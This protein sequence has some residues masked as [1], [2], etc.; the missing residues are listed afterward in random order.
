MIFYVILIGTS[1]MTK[2]VDL[3]S[4]SSSLISLLNC[5]CKYYVH[6]YQIFYSYF[7]TFFKSNSYQSVT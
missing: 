4:F 6:S 2:K 1:L 7:K 5:L 3:L